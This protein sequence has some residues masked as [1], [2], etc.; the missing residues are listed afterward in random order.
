MERKSLQH[1]VR[2]PDTVNRSRSLL[3]LQFRKSTIQGHRTRFVFVTIKLSNSSAAETKSYFGFWISGSTSGLRLIVNVEQYEHMRGPQ[4]DA[5]VK[6][7]T[8]LTILNISCRI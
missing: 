4:N 8:V 5:G 6:V 2:F 1:F 7:N 3:H